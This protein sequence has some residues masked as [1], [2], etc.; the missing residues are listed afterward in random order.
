[1]NVQKYLE[2]IGLANV[3]PERTHAF[4]KA[5]QLAHVCTVPYENID[6]ID[7]IPLSLDPEKLYEKIVLRHRG[8]YCFELNC[9][10]EHMLRAVGFC[11]VS[12]FARFWRGETGTPLRRHRVIAV[13]LDEKTYVVDVGIGSVAPRIPLLLEEGTVQEY[14][15]EQYR[16]AREETFGWVLYEMRGGEWQRYF[17]FTEDA[18]LDLDFTAISYY[19]E[20]H[21]DSKF[22]KAYMV[23]MKTETGRKTLDGRCYKEFAG[24][25]LVRIEEDMSD[26]RRDEVLR[27][28]FAIVK[29]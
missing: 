29:E 21:P 8:G 28:E 10:L 20:K 1:M 11:T 17:S 5:V 6:I 23:A 24:Q 27:N 9:L 26:T 14:F 4:L 3:E 12:Y 2:R 16:F 7:G 18:Q 19:C 13:L 15:G 22:N 25:E